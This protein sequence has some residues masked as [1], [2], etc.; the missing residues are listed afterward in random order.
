M[1][2]YFCSLTIVEISKFFIYQG[3]YFLLLIYFQSGVLFIEE[4]RHGKVSDTSR[5]IRDLGRECWYLFALRPK[6][7][8]C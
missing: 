5:C 8:L 1:L 3:I 2:F 6:L 7:I 4:Q